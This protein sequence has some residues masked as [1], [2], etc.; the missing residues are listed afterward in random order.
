MTVP[1]LP[2]FGIVLRGPIIVLH[3]GSRPVVERIPQPLVAGIAHYP[4]FPLPALPRHRS[5]PCIFSQSL[6][7]SFSEGL[8]G[9][10]QH[11]GADHP[12]NSRQGKQDL[13]VTM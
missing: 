13:G 11:R 8:R 7:I 5:S 1:S 10:T 12:P 2:H 4:H 9:L 6:I 3:A